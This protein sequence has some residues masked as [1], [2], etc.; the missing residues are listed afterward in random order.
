[1]RHDK[2]FVKTDAGPWTSQSSRSETDRLRSGISAVTAHTSTAL[3]NMRSAELIRRPVV[4]T[5]KQE[6]SLSL[7]LRVRTKISMV[8]I[9]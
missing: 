8:Y 4:A 1:M 3:D 7:A 5:D 2:Q 6:I 9:S